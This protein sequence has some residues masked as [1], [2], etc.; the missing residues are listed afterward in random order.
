MGQVRRVKLKKDFGMIGSL[1]VKDEVFV[2]YG[3]KPGIF[4]PEDMENPNGMMGLPVAQFEAR[5]MFNEYFEELEGVEFKE[6]SWYKAAEKETEG[7]WEQK[8][9]EYD[10]MIASVNEEKE[11][12]TTLLS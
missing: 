11:K 3:D 2:E 9:A 4:Y 7:Y 6:T 12:L 10:A 5:E 8:L 1:L